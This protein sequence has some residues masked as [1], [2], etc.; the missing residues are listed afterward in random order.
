MSQILVIDDDE[1]LRRVLGQILVRAGYSVT[2][3]AD[4]RQGLRAF[5][6][7]PAE[8]VICDLIMPDQEG[9]ET[10]SVLRKEFPALKIIAISGGARVTGYD[11]LPAAT[12]LGANLAIS[13]P[14]SREQ[15]L[16]SV[17]KLIGK[18]G[19]ASP[20]PASV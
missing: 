16:E 14:F 2:E 20:A 5:R 17:E 3:A 7:S 8:L 4:G 19:S 10:I 12:G 18:A 9:L 15:I 11:F 6:K 1:G 13:K